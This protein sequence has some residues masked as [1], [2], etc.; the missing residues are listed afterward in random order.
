[1]AVP[2]FELVLG[3]ELK[4]GDTI[5]P[6]YERP[7]TIDRLTPYEGRLGHLFKSGAAIAWFSPGSDFSGGRMTVDLGDYYKRVIAPS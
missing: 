1:M 7:A 6:W 4:P 3:S 5:V 2:P